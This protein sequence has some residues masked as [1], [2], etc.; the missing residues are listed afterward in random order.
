MYN[1]IVQG[2]ASRKILKESLC[3]SK[4]THSRDR[5]YLESFTKG[6]VVIPLAT[7]C[8]INET[9]FSYPCPEPW[10]AFKLPRWLTIRRCTPT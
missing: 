7:K 10:E 9:R 2:F 8:D 4:L 1:V 3:N 6:Y 5:L